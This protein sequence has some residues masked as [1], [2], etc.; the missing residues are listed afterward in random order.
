[1]ETK[2]NPK[3][4]LEKRRTMMF[5]IGLIVSLGLTLMA[6]EWKTPDYGGIKLPPPTTFDFPEDIGIQLT[7]QPV[8]PPKAMN[9]T[10]MRITDNENQ[11]TVDLNIDAGIDID[12]IVPVFVAP[13]LTEELPDETDEPFIIVEDMPVFAGGDAGLLAYLS[14]NIKYP[15]MARES[16]I[17]GTVYITFVVEK[18]GSLSDI[19]ALREVGGGC[20]A[21]ALRVIQTMPRWT[22]GKQRGVPVRVRINLPVKFMLL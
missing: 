11:H 16:G 17:T 3:A 10:L 21:E 7:R 13:V 20:T 6:F 14:Q 1:M 12:E 5:Q 15:V 9:T 18:D 19:R 2:K 4:D 22:P 8:E